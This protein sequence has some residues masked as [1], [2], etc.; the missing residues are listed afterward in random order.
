ME[1]NHSEHFSGSISSSD[2]SGEDS[3][4]APYYMNIN[5]ELS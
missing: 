1:T 3:H 4:A 2:D 5:K